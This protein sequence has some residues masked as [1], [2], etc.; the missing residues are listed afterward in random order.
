MLV[1]DHVHVHQSL[2]MLPP[3]KK[4]GPLQC[5]TV[6]FNRLARWWPPRS[7]LTATAGV[8][9]STWFNNS[10][11]WSML[12][13]QLGEWARVC[14]ADGST[15]EVGSIWPAWPDE[16]DDQSNQKGQ[17]CRTRRSETAEKCLQ[18]CIW[19]HLLSLLVVTLLLCDADVV[20][21][22][23]QPQNTPL[24]LIYAQVMTA[25]KRRSKPPS[26]RS[27]RSILSFVT[28]RT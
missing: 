21:V 2:A 3:L 17:N 8:N 1:H 4:A 15:K 5:S 7:G 18:L 20:D 19:T 25:Q 24:L 9:A 27:W 26:L 13:K 12:F 28:F 10:Q 11:W 14:S 23:I 16:A 22:A 6:A